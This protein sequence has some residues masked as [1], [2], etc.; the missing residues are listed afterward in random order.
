MKNYVKQRLNQ[1]VL[2]LTLMMS[3]SACG[4]KPKV[5]VKTVPVPYAVPQYLEYD[6]TQVECKKLVLAKGD[7]WGNAIDNRDE[8]IEK[9]VLDI[10]TIRK[11]IN[12]DN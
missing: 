7:K 3:L 2:V 4:N 6:F 8:M 11:T 5:V 1:F 10:E 9:C 12:P